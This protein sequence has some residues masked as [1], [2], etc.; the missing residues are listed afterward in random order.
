MPM[1]VNLLGLALIGL[2]VWWFWLWRPQA[3]AQAREGV[4]EITVAD[5]VYA[6]ARIEVPTGRPTIL[7]FL[8]KDPSPCA[9]Q[10]HISDL[11]LVL[12]LPLNKTRDL[13]V[14][15]DTPG[16]YEFTCQMRMYRG[17]LIARE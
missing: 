11:G 7:R 8:R 12:E 16:R 10:V 17:E 15:P 6:P 14:K 13:V 9:E 2:I 4:V 5:G 3:A 1:L